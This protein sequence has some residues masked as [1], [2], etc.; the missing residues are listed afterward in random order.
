MKRPSNHELHGKLKS[1][2]ETAKAGCFRLVEPAPIY[3]DLTDLGILPE[4]LPDLIPKIV[5]E[6]GPQDY[7]GK[8]PPEKSYEVSIKGC[9]L[10]AFKWVSKELG[11][12]MYFKFAL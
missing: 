11:C 12:M 4:D 6:I 5:S 3:A 2:S 1:A 9:E 10:Y 8:K 7:K